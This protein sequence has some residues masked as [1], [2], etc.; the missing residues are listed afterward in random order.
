MTVIYLPVIYNIYIDNCKFM[1]LIFLMPEDP[2]NTK[3]YVLM[4]SSDASIVAKLF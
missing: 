4:F 1:E 3:N 2:E